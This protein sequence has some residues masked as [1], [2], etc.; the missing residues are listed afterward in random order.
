MA[1]GVLDQLGRLHIVHGTITAV[2]ATDAALTSNDGSATLTRGAAGEYVV[3]F[4]DA[5]TS[6]ESH[7]F[8]REKSR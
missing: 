3:T 4:G 2:D 7:L 1:S 8:R 6:T 5:F